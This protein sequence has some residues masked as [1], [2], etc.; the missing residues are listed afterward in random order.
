[1]RCHKYS[2]NFDPL[3]FGFTLGQFQLKSAKIL[4]KTR[5]KASFISIIVYFWLIKIIDHE[6]V[7]EKFIMRICL[8]LDNPQKLFGHFCKRARKEKNVSDVYSSLIKSFS[9]Y[10][11]QTTFKTVFYLSLGNCMFIQNFSR[12]FIAF[13]AKCLCKTRAYFAIFDLL[14]IFLKNLFQN[15]CHIFIFFSCLFTFNSC[16]FTFNSCLFTLNSCLLSF[17]SCLIIFYSCLLTIY[18]CLITFKNYL[19]TIYCCLFTIYCCLFT[20]YSC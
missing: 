12:C 11:M 16:L 19:F 5:R 3:S 13:S 18:S 20:I 14:F 9:S 2:G 4:L 15:S 1:M 6:I 17:S 7:P 8:F 10:Y